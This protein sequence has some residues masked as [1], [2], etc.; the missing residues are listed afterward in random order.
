MKSNIIMYLL[1]LLVSLT[2]LSCRDSGTNPTQDQIRKD[3]TA[4]QK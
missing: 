2:I 3:L 1:I 4:A